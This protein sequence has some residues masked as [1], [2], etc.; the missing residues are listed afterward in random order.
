MVS[1]NVTALSRQK[2]S[3]PAAAVSL[4]TA[5]RPSSACVRL[6]NHYKVKNRNRPPMQQGGCTAQQLTLL[7][8]HIGQTLHN[9]L[10]GNPAVLFSL[11]SLS[12][13]KKK[14]L[15]IHFL[16]TV[17]ANYCYTH[18]Y[19]LLR[20]PHFTWCHASDISPPDQNTLPPLGFFQNI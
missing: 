15:F 3:E 16:Y 5:F 12:L 1:I 14:D 13:F 17:G 4:I 8:F 11:G 10:Y 7:C 9:K 19:M 6:T 18:Y 2:H 20:S